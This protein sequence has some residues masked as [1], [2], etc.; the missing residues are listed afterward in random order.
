[1]KFGAIPLDGF[2]LPTKMVRY[3]AEQMVWL[4][5]RFG[6]QYE[7]FERFRTKL[8]LFVIDSEHFFEFFQVIHTEPKMIPRIE[9]N[10]KP[11]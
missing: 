3:S 8:P 10:S 7:T 5:N 1:M 4:R 2:V 11:F 9:T 6:R